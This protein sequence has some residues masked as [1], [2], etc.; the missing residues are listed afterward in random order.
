MFLFRSADRQAQPT[1]QQK[2]PHINVLN[3]SGILKSNSVLDIALP[4]ET[5]L[6]RWC[7]LLEI[8]AT[9][10]IRETQEEKHGHVQ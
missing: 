10:L 4:K 9:I 6:S 3:R 1:L 2:Q 8:V 7:V 5:L